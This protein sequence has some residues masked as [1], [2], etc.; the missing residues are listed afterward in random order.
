MIGK[1]TRQVHYRLRFGIFL[2]SLSVEERC[3]Y[4]QSVELVWHKRMPHVNMPF[5]GFRGEDAGPPLTEGED[6]VL[7]CQIRLPCV[8]SPCELVFVICYQLF[9]KAVSFLT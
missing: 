9:N 8:P 6:G 4:C 2:T 7:G 3:L 5:D 1:Y